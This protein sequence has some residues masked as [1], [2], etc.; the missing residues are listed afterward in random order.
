MIKLYYNPDDIP[1]DVFDETIQ[2]LAAEDGIARVLAIPGVWEHV[3]E[4]YNND[5]IVE[6]VSDDDAD[7]ENAADGAEDGGDTGGMTPMKKTVWLDLTLRASGINQDVLLVVSM[8]GQDVRNSSLCGRHAGTVE[9]LYT[10]ALAAAEAG[11]AAAQERVGKVSDNTKAYVDWAR[12]YNF[13][14]V[15]EYTPSEITAT[16]RHQ[17][18]PGPPA[19]SDWH[20][21]VRAALIGG[22]GGIRLRLWVIRGS[23]LLADTYQ[24]LIVDA[25]VWSGLNWTVE[26][27]LLALE[28]ELRANIERVMD[29]NRAGRADSAGPD[30]G[31]EQ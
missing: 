26:A 3:A 25:D 30:T 5:A 10:A 12:E 21:D 16:F 1:Q 7:A 6:L 27:G 24:P 28:Q 14:G 23:H 18:P 31:D 20:R 29:E 19:L 13:G 9:D 2:R 22:V 15:E 11:R 8:S 17:P 4:Y